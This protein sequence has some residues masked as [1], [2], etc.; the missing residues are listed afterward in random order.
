MPDRRA[1]RWRSLYENRGRQLF[2]AGLIVGAVLLVI[3]ITAAT[4]TLGRITEETEM[5][6]N[7]LRRQ[8]ALN[9]LST[10]NEQIENGR[11]GFLIQ[12]DPVFARV[13]REATTGFDRELN[14][15]RSLFASDYE[16]RESLDRIAELQ[17]DRID[18]IDETFADPRRVAARL[19]IPDR[20][21]TEPTGSEGGETRDFNP[22]ELDS[23]GSEP[24]DDNP[25]SVSET[26][27]PSDE[28][29]DT[30]PALPELDLDADPGVLI[31]REIRAITGSLAQGQEEQLRV[32]NRNQLDS[33]VQFYVVGGL[34]FFVLLALMG[35]VIVLVLRYNRDLT[36]AQVGLR[37]ANDTLESTVA[38]RTAALSRANEEIQRFAYI[39]SH[40]LRSPLVNVLGFTAE[41]DEA[42]KLIHAHLE[43]IYRDHPELRDEG[44][45]LAVDE[46]LP[47]ALGF[48][49]TSTE[50][51]DRLINSILELSRQ[52][53]RTLKPEQL[54]MEALVEGIVASLQQRIEE[55]GAQVTVGRIPDLESD[56]IAIE[57]ILQNL[58]ENALKYL[59]PKRAGEVT[60][61]GSRSSG[62]VRIDVTDN[63]R[64]IA[65]DDH[66]RIFDLFRRA[67]AQD[68]KGE[69]IG[70]ANVRALAYRL[71]GTVEV[72][73]ELDQGARFRLLLPA[74]FSPQ[75]SAT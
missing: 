69:G 42:R 16:G 46:D 8:T 48:I 27:D 71:G 11:R 52:G 24:L 3:A 34:A 57:Q 75:E 63:G 28:A 51:M 65:P 66:Q 47:E 18:L 62:M 10:F 4:M 54:E 49:R 74:D 72:E 29:A 25:P 50:K 39:V 9:R 73:S 38:A 1:S 64:G 58:I 20:P 40:D 35:T 61:E 43:E 44:A 19:L 14:G 56:R 6:E 37:R 17:A 68:Q 45:W 36:A 70:L 67:G 59:S 60:I 55:A 26:A 23:P 22:F 7:T 53:R 12:P 32:R 41:L 5:V 2:A 15:L 33:L 31:L 30:A 13:I 21:P